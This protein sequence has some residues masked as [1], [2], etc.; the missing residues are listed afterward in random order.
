MEGTVPRR[1]PASRMAAAL[2][3]AILILLPSSPSTAYSVLTHE[4]VVDFLWNSDI[5]RILLERYPATTADELKKAH[6]YAYGGSLI[7]DMGYYPHGNKLFSDL[8]HYV[9][10][11]DFVIELVRDSENVNELAFSLGALAHYAS[12]TNGHP[13]VNEAVSRTFPKLRAKY[14]RDVTYANDPKAHIRT[15]FGLDVVE[16]AQQHYASPSFHDFIG[17]QVAQPLLERAFLRTYGVPLS[18]VLPDEEKSIESYRHALSVWIPRLTE[19][20]LITKKKEL[21]ATPDF[22]PKKFRY[23]LHRTEYEREWGK[24]YSKP[25]FGARF[26]AVVVKILPKIGPLATLDIKTPDKQSE[27]LFVESVEQTVAVY[28]GLLQQAADPENVLADR[29]LDTGRPTSAAEYDLADKTYARLLK[30]LA[31]DG[32]ARTTP[33]LRANVLGFYSDLNLPIETKRHKD[34]WSE[35][36]RDLDALK[37]QTVSRAEPNP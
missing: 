10:S 18:Q 5:K 3:A 17:F 22:D 34:D 28:H 8:V 2:L 36:L 24:N 23:I 35:V 20:A 4:Q 19:V 37:K 32:Y 6:A 15:E 30:L 27:K 21:Q 12:D 33:E 13:A 14:G 9:R 7:Q 25:G 31:K 16:V 26:L 1:F 29:D 11:G